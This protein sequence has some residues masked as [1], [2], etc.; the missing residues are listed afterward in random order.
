MK[1]IHTKGTSARLLI[2]MPW[3]I[4]DTI[5]VGLSAIDQVDRDDPDGSVAVDV[6]CNHIQAEVLEQD[7]RIHHLIEIDDSL[8]PTSAAGTWKRGLF[9]SPR[10]VT[11]ARYLR[12][13]HYTAQLPFMFA[14]SFFFL[15]HTPIIFLNPFE[16]WK[17]ISKI[18]TLGDTSIPHIIRYIVN[19][20]FEQ[21]YGETLPEPGVDEPTP[22]YICPEYVREAMHIVAGIKAQASIPAERSRILL[23]APDTSSEITRPPTSLLADGI[24]EALK[25]D[26]NLLAAILPGYSD[27]ESSTRLLHELAPSFAGRIFL[28]QGEPKMP[29]LELAALIDQSDIFVTGDTGTMHL[30]AT[31]KMIPPTVNNDVSPRNTVKIITLF[32][33][34]NPGLHGYNER[35]IILGKGRKEQTKFAPGVAKDMYK[36]DGKNFFDHIPPCQLTEAIMHSRDM[37]V[38]R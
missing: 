7:P 31:Y 32:G 6:L 35:T 2:T 18:R 22:L 14:P 36:P 21:Y 29:L 37:L 8:F 25:R 4:G 24:A 34:T 10:T 27:T 33:G 19:K 17:V 1:K 26:A 20:F 13:Q 15:L 38:E 11:L 30:A 9:L 5:S 16:G 28:R 12:K 3:G 23:V